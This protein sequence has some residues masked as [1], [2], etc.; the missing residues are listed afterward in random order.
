MPVNCKVCVD[1]AVLVT[2]ED[3]NGCMWADSLEIYGR[4][5]PVVTPVVTVNDFCE[6]SSAMLSSSSTSVLTSSIWTG[7]V[8]EGVPFVAATSM[9]G[10]Y[11]VQGTDAYGCTH[12]AQTSIGIYVGIYDPATTS[13][14]V[15]PNPFQD[16]WRSIAAAR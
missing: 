9:S 15:Y 11:T 13:L 16:R 6:G 1:V 12:I 4:V 14:Q 5:A 10:T 8:L 3:A 7:G 2:V